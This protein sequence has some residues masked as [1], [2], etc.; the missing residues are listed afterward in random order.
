MVESCISAGSHRS[1]RKIV[2][3][4][5]KRGHC[6]AG[7]WA[8]AP[9]LAG[10][11]AQR[12]CMSTNLLMRMAPLWRNSPRAVHIFTRLPGITPALSWRLRFWPS[13]HGGEG[14]S[15][16]KGPLSA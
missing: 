5:R 2:P 12:G 9:T 15:K 4:S 10:S 14:W 13:P 3:L 16:C 11:D 1:E 8:Q 7:L 6:L